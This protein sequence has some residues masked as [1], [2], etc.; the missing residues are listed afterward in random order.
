[1]IRL[2]RHTFKRAVLALALT[3]ASVFVFTE[4][5]CRSDAFI[6]RS[7]FDHP[8]DSVLVLDRHGTPLRVLRA[9][10]GL[11]HRWISLGEVSPSLLT[12]LIA[13]EDSRFFS[14]HG[15][16]FFS[17]ARAAITLTGLYG[18]RSGA[19]T[20]TQQLIKLVYGRPH[21]LFDKPLEVLRAQA[22][23]HRMSKD[24]I[25]EQYI[26]RL[27]F[28]NGIVG[29][30]RASEAYF[31]HDAATLTQSESALLVGIPQAPSRYEPW[32][33]RSA[34]LRRRAVVLR[35]MASAGLIDASQLGALSIA[36]PA[37]LSIAP[38]PYVAPRY[39][40]QLSA[41]RRVRKLPPG[42]RPG[43]I[44]SALDLPLQR[45]AHDEVSNTVQRF[46]ARGVLNGAAIVLANA[47][48]EV[49]GYVSAVDG[50]GAAIDLLTARR[51]PGS[52]LKPFVYERWFERGGAPTEIVADVSVQR[53]GHLGQSFEARDYDNHE[54]GPTP[55]ASALASSLNLAALD[56]ASRVGA[57]RLVSHLRSLGFRLPRAA[58]DYGS[59]IVLGGA[60]VS[61]IELARAWSTLARGGTLPTLSFLLRTDAQPGQFVMLR[62][63]A[64]QTWRVL[65]DPFL[66]RMGFG[67]DL[68]RDGPPGQF[69]IK[70]GTSSQ[71]R[72][73]WAAASTRRHTVVVWLGDPWGSPMASV[74]GFTAAAPLAARILAAAERLSGAPPPV[75]TEARFVNARICTWSGLR[76]GPSCRHTLDGQFLPNQIPTTVCSSHDADGTN[77]LDARY[78]RWIERHHPPNVRARASQSSPRELAIEAPAD[79]TQLLI[80]PLGSSVSISLRSNRTNA[81]WRID[82]RPHPG[83]RWRLSLGEH[84]LVAFAGTSQS[85]PV[86]VT[87]ASVRQPSVTA[88]G[89]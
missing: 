53:T 81:L 77:L 72:D 38:H 33:H 24:Q 19:S 64:E 20:I 60:E 45:I 52:S 3:S 57:D 11:D 47:T 2:N 84:T 67:D 78:F 63:A 58:S 9:P 16:D 10:D 44:V 49:L 65:S 37:T 25:L 14:H 41:L 86:R 54:R 55:A 59:A 17:S 76:A 87:V 75:I 4:L 79:G 66:R 5:L 7:R 43:S 26:N 13:V 51:A 21:G 80:D 85:A 89:P 62:G 15:V 35:R 40:D 70:T 34:S 31:G 82:G 68:S 69:A 48:G 29:V 27:P 71:W 39:T 74:S 73:A 18:R 8:G 1:M 22:L 61:P 56:V 30:A 42:P 88:P 32:R 50:S 28:G 83:S 36:P 46:R 6:D 12:A 23:E